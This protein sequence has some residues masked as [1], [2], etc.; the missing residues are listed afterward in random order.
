MYYSVAELFDCC[1]IRL[2]SQQWQC[3]GGVGGHTAAAALLYIAN[4][5][6]QFNGNGLVGWSHCLSPAGVSTVMN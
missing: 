4:N 2:P 3:V 1:I 6:L 5:V